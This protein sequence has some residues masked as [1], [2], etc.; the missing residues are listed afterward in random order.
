MPKYLIRAECLVEFLVDAESLE[1]AMALDCDALDAQPKEIN[2]V[3]HIYEG[4]ER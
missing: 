1:V 4:E 3:Y 2:E